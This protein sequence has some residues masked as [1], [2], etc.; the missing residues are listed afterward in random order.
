MRN[1]ENQLIRKTKSTSFTAHR[2]NVKKSVRTM[3]TTREKSG[4][5]KI[6]VRFVG[7]LFLLAIA[8]PVFPQVN[9]Y[10]T[11]ALTAD[12]L[13]SS[14]STPSVNQPYLLCTFKLFNPDTVPFYIWVSFKNSGKLKHVKHGDE[15]P[16]LRLTDLEL[17]YKNA[18]GLPMVKKFQNNSFDY[19]VKKRF[20]GAWL[21]SGRA[22]K[23]RP[24]AEFADEVIDGVVTTERGRHRRGASE[25]AFWKED[26]QGY[27]EME[28]WGVLY[29]Q[30]LDGM[31]VAGVYMDV[32][33]FEIEIM[34]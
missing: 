15:F 17:H 12:N 31:V 18:L 24:R 21:S 7:T 9:P 27:Y 2:Q 1:A 6:A 20:G 5:T 22:G 28:L 30:D 14:N 3:Y 29:E 32:V 25:I 34:K 4:T 19:R 10:I 8:C 33:N 11:D 13:Q 26:A 16:E 23:K